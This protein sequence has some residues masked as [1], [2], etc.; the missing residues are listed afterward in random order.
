[1]RRSSWTRATGARSLGARAFGA[2]AFGA[3]LVY[4]AALGLSA[5]LE[6]QEQPLPELFKDRA[7]SVNIQARVVE[8]EQSAAWESASLRYTVPGNPVGV[9]LVGSNVVI[10]VQIT[11]FEDGK[12]GLVLVSQGQVWVRRGEGDLSYRTTLDSVSVRYGEPVLF[13]PLGRDPGGKAPIRIEISVDRYRGAP[14][15]G[16]PAPVSSP[17]PPAAEGAKP[18]K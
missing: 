3:A 14:V 10:L 15:P 8:G 18:K 9:K 4:A 2:R 11:P 6:A 13:F 12:G 1:M 16:A 5:R 17:I 7:L